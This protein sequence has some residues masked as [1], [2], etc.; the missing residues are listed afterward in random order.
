[1]TKHFNV[2]NTLTALRLV[3][4]PVMLVLA[5]LNENF[6]LGIVFVAA[7]VTDALDGFFARILKQSTNFGAWFDTIADDLLGLSLPFLLYLVNPI[8]FTG[9]RLWAGLI[10]VLFFL[11]LI[12]MAK[13]KKKSIVFHLYSSKLNA[14]A[15]F[16]F[17]SVTFLYS[18][19][20]WLF[21]VAIVIVFINF[22]ELFLLIRSDKHYDQHTKSYF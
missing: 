6:A 5:F 9:A 15:L 17:G 21:W 12:Y 14:L 18:F 20:P 1:M 16:V 13:S 22:V 10:V 19:L 3:S 7:W 11:I 4:I 2:P 8:I